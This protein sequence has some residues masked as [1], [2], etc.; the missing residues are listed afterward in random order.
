MPTRRD[1]IEQVRREIYNGNAP[2]DAT[3]TV[4]LVNQW[5]NQ[6]IGVCVKKNYSD[7]YQIEGI[8]YINNSFYTTY[9]GIA[10]TK[11]ENFL[12]KL[13]LPQIPFGI[14][15]NEG[16]S[17]LQFK[18]TDSQVSYTA[19]PLSTNQVTIQSGM[20]P[21][22]GK[23]LYYP[24]GIYCYVLTTLGLFQYTATVKLISG[25]DSTDLDS[26]LNVPDDYLIYAT[27]Y[28]QKQLLLEKSQPTDTVNDG[29]DY[30]TRTRV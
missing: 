14:G 6:A 28:I 23:L 30:P 17:M 24:E 2:N 1:Y 16:I 7:S 27:E 25:G 12:Y 13:T 11:D 19:V 21:I 18:G 26:V 9:K 5:L 8:N 29:T 20:R 22:P 3:I 10:V 4:G 15:K